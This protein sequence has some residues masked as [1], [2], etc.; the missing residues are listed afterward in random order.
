[1]AADTASKLDHQ[2]CF[3]LYA[4][5]NAMTRL[6]RDRLEPLGLTYPQYLVML[7]LWEQDGLTVSGHH[8]V[9]TLGDRLHLDSGTL[10]PMLK[11]MEQAGLLARTRSTEDERQVAVSLTPKGRALQRDVAALQRD[12]ACLLPLDPKDLGR[13]RAELRGLADCLLAREAE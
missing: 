12:L 2:L 10:T 11:R 8:N 13:L 3:A 4:A 6:Y 1:M 7:V 9:K 5:S